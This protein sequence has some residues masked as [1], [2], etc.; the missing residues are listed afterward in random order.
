MN[1]DTARTDGGLV[2]IPPMSALEQQ[3]RSAARFR[4]I[5]EI[6][7]DQCETE[8]ARA[9]AREIAEDMRRIEELDVVLPRVRL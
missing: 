4:Q 1:G 9:R 7:A 6:I 8:C 5:A 3:K 2:V